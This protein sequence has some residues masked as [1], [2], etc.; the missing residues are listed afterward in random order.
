MR[1]LA[2]LSTKN[3]ID[4][5]GLAVAPKFAMRRS[6]PK[7]LIICFL[8]LACRPPNTLQTNPPSQDPEPLNPIASTEM[9][10]ILPVLTVL[11]SATTMHLC[12]SLLQSFAASSRR[13][14]GPATAYT[15]TPR[16][17]VPQLVLAAIHLARPASRAKNKLLCSNPTLPL[18][19]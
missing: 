3:D 5:Q 11:L 9:R 7:G 17:T 4:W 6:T 12:M 8:Q 1:C 18:P 13:K 2:Q 15:I 14:H 10:S 19:P 16:P